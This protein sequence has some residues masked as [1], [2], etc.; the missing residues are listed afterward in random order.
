M[1]YAYLGMKIKGKVEWPRSE[2]ST[3]VVKTRFIFQGLFLFFIPESIHPTILLYKGYSGINIY[4]EI[5]Q[6]VQKVLS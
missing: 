3:P 2:T 6:N 4:N 5:L 1:A